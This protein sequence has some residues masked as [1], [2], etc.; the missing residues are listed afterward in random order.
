MQ[1]NN[2][3]K[4]IAI[5]S[6]ML[7]LITV[8]SILEHMIPPLPFLPP[9]VKIGL[10]NIVTM[11]TLFFL[12]KKEAF[13]L[14]MLKSTFVLITRGFI[15]GILSL[16][17]GLCSLSVILLSIMIF[18]KNVSYTML[19]ILGALTHN[20]AQLMI[21]SLLNQTNLWFYY[22]PVLIISAIIMGSLTGYLLKVV[23]PA[24]DSVFKKR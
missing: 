24:F 22:L 5:L 6:M 12:G 23:M 10:S 20:L 11:Y 8:L 2:K 16:G 18:K 3:P 19:S 21:V 9:N 7:A 1:N 4:Y 15:A 13:I 14:A 17:G